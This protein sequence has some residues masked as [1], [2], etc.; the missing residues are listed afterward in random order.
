MAGY[1]PGQRI[2][3]TYWVKAFKPY[4]DEWSPERVTAVLEVLSP[5][6]AR[7][8]S[9]EMEPATSRRQIYAMPSYRDRQ[10]GKV[11]LIS[12]LDSVKVIE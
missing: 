1:T 7:V 10:I 12:K 3:A 5:G 11:K 6:K 4:M 2:S 9:A 8:I